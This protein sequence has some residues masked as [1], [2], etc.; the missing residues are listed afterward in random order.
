MAR[1]VAPASKLPI[2]VR[3][4]RPPPPLTLGVTTSARHGKKRSYDA[5]EGDLPPS[6]SLPPSRA[7]SPNGSTR[8]WPTSPPSPHPGPQGSSDPSTYYGGADPDAS[9]V[10]LRLRGA[11]PGIYR[12]ANAEVGAT[13]GPIHQWPDPRPNPGL[14]P[15]EDVRCLICLGDLD[16]EAYIEPRDESGI[17]RPNASLR[18]WLSLPALKIWACRIRGFRDAPSGLRTASAPI[19][20]QM[21]LYSGTAV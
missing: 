21:R 20:A 13:D 15:E 1:P 4:D 6:P 2:D 19:S 9:R 12:W 7:T 18:Q 10:H 17:A 5:V 8:C 11:D 16:A 3:Q 14:Y